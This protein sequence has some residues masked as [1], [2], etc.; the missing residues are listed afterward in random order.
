VERKD[1]KEKKVEG[2]KMENVDTCCNHKS[3]GEE[4]TIRD[5]VSGGHLT[6]ELT[7]ALLPSGICRKVTYHMIPIRPRGAAC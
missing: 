5:A 1:G 4:R 7:D 6:R 3:R 2:R